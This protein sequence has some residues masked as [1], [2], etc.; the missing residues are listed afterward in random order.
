MTSGNT[1]ENQHTKDSDTDEYEI[2]H[3]SPGKAKRRKKDSSVK[4][5]QNK[6]NSAENVKNSGCFKMVE[7]H[8]QGIVKKTE[9]ASNIVRSSNRAKITPCQDNINIHS[10]C[11]QNSDSDDH[12]DLELLSGKHGS[13]LSSHVHVSAKV[14]L[15]FELSHIN[16]VDNSNSHHIEQRTGK[17]HQFVEETA[18]EPQTKLGVHV[19]SQ[20]DDLDAYFTC[21]GTSQCSDCKI[22][23]SPKQ[24]NETN[25][26][27]E[28]A[29]AKEHNRETG[30]IEPTQR[31]QP[32]EGF[33]IHTI[34]SNVDRRVE[35]LLDSE[36]TKST[37]SVHKNDYGRPIDMKEGRESNSFHTGD[38]VNCA[39]CEAV[40]YEGKE[41]LREGDN[42][43]DIMDKPHENSREDIVKSAV[44]EGK[45]PLGGF[46]VSQQKNVQNNKLDCTDKSESQRKCY[47]D[48]AC[49]KPGMRRNLSA[50][51]RKNYVFPKSSVR[52]KPVRKSI[53]F[54]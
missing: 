42:H 18:S 41:T 19:I 16:L 44:I 25:F 32:L 34:D 10:N 13:E 33:V 7:K 3:N 24:H 26:S 37:M 2:D 14:K 38:D 46:E 5:Q 23:L 40:C 29:N 8:S 36:H 27:K 21:T 11:A 17:D 28:E 1:R 31:P 39:T 22:S 43:E 54:S 51:R 20:E 4:G 45:Y 35:N 49:A 50:V 52:V 15:N 48:S 47:S 30:D 53:S 12:A 6:D 9:Y